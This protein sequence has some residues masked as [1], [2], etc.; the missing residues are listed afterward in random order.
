[1]TQRL[2][3]RKTAAASVRGM[4]GK[5][6]FQ[7]TDPLSIDSQLTDEELMIKVRSCYCKR[8]DDQDQQVYAPTVVY[9]NPPM[10]T[11]RASCC[12]ASCRPTATP[13]SIRTS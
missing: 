13:R 10:T 3:A 8:D 4:A 12:R 6:S 9:R 7:W 11:A 2:V 1:M 5:A